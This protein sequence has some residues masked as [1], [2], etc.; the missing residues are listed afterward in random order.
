MELPIEVLTEKELSYGRHGI[1][2]ADT[3][4]ETLSLL[5]QNICGSADRY[6][7]PLSGN[8]QNGW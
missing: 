6:S 7:L 2:E 5:V 1:S 3:V 8:S 4:R